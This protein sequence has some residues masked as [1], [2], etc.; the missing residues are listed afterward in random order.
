MSGSQCTLRSGSPTL[1]P[2]ASLSAMRPTFIIIVCSSCSSSSS[3]PKAQTSI[4]RQQPTCA[5]AAA[6]N[7]ASYTS[8]LMASLSRARRLGELSSSRQV[9]LVAR[10]LEAQQML[11]LLRRDRAQRP[12]F[13]RSFSLSLIRQVANTAVYKSIFSLL[14][15]SSNRFGLFTRD[16][17]GSSSSSSLSGCCSPELD[18]LATSER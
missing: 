12:S 1:S 8:Q 6:A 5:A 17:N 10:T 3:R 16:V 14:L 13:C 18:C 4:S 9:E 11:H 7:L 15:T 2:V